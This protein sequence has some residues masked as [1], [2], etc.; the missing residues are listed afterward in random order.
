MFIRPVVIHPRG[1]LALMTTDMNNDDQKSDECFR[2]C[3]SIFGFQIC[4]YR[5]EYSQEEDFDLLSF[6]MV[7]D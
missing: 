4:F 7:T 6:F 1:E 2:Y 5:H 3:L